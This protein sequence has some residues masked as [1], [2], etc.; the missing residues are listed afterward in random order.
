MRTLK[1]L[2]FF[3]PLFLLFFTKTNAQIV[4]NNAFIK[5]NYVEIGINP[6]GVY[7]SSINAPTGYHPRL[8]SPSSFNLGFVADPDKDGWNIGIPNYH[9]DFFYPGSSARR[10]FHSI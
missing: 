7:G 3:S 10:V 5:G 2:L 4:S 6:Y 9:G 1:K 8:D